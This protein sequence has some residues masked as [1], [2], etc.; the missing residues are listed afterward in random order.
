ME[1]SDVNTDAQKLSSVF[2]SQVAISLERERGRERKGGVPTE[3]ANNYI[4]FYGT[5]T[6]GQGILMNRLID[7]QRESFFTEV[8]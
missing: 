6:V 8:R 7:L 5:R 1:S 3:M 4:D 2:N